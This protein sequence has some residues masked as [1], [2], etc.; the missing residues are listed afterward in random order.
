MPPAL[1]VALCTGPV[2]MPSNVPARQ[3]DAARASDSTTARALRGSGRPGSTAASSGTSLMRR[4]PDGTAGASGAA[5]SRPR[6][7][8]RAARSRLPRSPKATRSAPHSRCAARTQSSGPTPAGSPG[9]SASR[10]RRMSAPGADFD[11]GL[12]A[13]LA[14][15]AVPL[16][17]QLAHADRL[18]DPGATVLVVDVD[19]AGGEPLHDVPAGLGAE[20]G[21][22][23]AVL[24]ARDL[25]AEF[26]AELVQ[27]E[28][29][30]V[31]AAVAADGVVG[32]FAGDLGEVGA[33]G[34]ARAQGVDAGPGLG[35][36]VLA[37][38]GA[39]QDVA[40]VELGDLA[41]VGR[42]VAHLDQLQQLEAAG[43]AHRPVDITRLHVADDVGE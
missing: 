7:M 20:R 4:V 3:P 2:T 40:R 11:E 5:K 35:V 26:G 36:A 16:V 41:G 1:T 30:Q 39:D 12:A 43:A 18:P 10:G 38:A 21:G 27:G 37:L 13:L 14:E 28:P 32:G 29:A 17:L 33:A 19:L 42:A 8:A 31:A 9:T 24:Q 23:L 34:D 6:P 15:E 22:N 25:V